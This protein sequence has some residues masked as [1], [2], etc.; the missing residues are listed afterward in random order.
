MLIPALHM[1]VDGNAPV[2]AQQHS[3]ARI[4]LLLDYNPSLVS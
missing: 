3:I 2:A 1:Q 4:L